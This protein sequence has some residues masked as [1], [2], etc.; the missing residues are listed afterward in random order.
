MKL[1]RLI[2]KMKNLKKRKISKKFN[3]KMMKEMPM[4]MLQ[5]K[6][7]VMMIQLLKMRSVMMK[8]SKRWRTETSQ[9]ISNLLVL[10]MMM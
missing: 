2:N 4:M 8:K 1:M 9:L 6:M 10:L 7:K 3:N 5:T